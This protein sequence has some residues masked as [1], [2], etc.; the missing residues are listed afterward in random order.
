MSAIMR[1]YRDKGCYAEFGFTGIQW[2]RMDAG[3]AG[4]PWSEHLG[5]IAALKSG[6]RLRLNTAGDLPGE[7]DEIDELRLFEL[8]MA[9]K[10]TTRQAWTYTHKPPTPENLEA[11]ATAVQLGL[12]INLSAD[13]PAEADKLAK[14]GFPV[15]VVIPEDAP[16]RYYTPEGTRI[17]T[18][19]AQLSKQTTCGNCGGKGVALCARP[20]RDYHIGFR[21]HGSMKRTATT[22]AWA[23]LKPL[24]LFEA[25][26]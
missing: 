3:N 21:A 23:G 5:Q 19:P 20:E 6:M 4:K 13:S 8:A 22:T 17:V 25:K 11:L 26:S 18:C 10:A 15:A 1:V 2:R 16:R 12:V 14:T 7:G 9:C 24:P